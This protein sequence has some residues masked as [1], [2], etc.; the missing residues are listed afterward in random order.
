MC[1]VLPP[2]AAGSAGQRITPGLGVHVGEPD[3]AQG[4]D[5][6]GIEHRGEV[7]LPGGPG[8]NRVIWHRW[9]P[10]SRPELICRKGAWLSWVGQAAQS[11]PS[12]ET[13]VCHVGRGPLCVRAGGH[14]DWS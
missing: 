13:V 14:A 6:G 1:G 10:I 12:G 8:C 2:G 7:L 3:L 4:L 5:G 9:K 11:W